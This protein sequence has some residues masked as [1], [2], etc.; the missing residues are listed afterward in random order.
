[1]R[2]S[3]SLLPGSAPLGAPRHGVADSE[4]FSSESFTL[5]LCQC[6]F[7]VVWPLLWS[8]T[9][10]EARPHSAAARWRLYVVRCT[11]SSAYRGLRSPGAGSGRG[12]AAGEPDGEQAG[13][14]LP[15][16]EGT[17]SILL[18]GAQP[19]CGA[20]HRPRA[21]EL[22]RASHSRPL[23]RPGSGQRFNHR[24]LNRSGIGPSRGQDPNAA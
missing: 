1:M 2:L 3:A 16:K 20:L 17:A 10:F 18:T 8:G 6:R 19:W 13:S 5:M 24:C 21:V 14:M 12:G 11:R 22:F 23:P 9:G 7:L 15:A 4:H